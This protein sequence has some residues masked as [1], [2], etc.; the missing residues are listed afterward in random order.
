M[1]A[2]EV[3]SYRAVF[4]VGTF[5]LGSFVLGL[6]VDLRRKYDLQ[7]P[8]RF[9]CPAR[10]EFQCLWFWLD[11]YLIH[12]DDVGKRVLRKEPD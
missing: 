6:G 3:L 11:V 7:Y 4:K 12:P 5:P 9:V 8:D 1:T 10:L 2:Q